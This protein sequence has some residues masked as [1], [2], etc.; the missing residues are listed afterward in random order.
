MTLGTS[1]TRLGLDRRL[2]WWEIERILDLAKAETDEAVGLAVQSAILDHAQ[3]DPAHFR[4]YEH[5]YQLLLTAPYRRSAYYEPRTFATFE[6]EPEP[7]FSCQGEVRDVDP[8]DLPDL[9]ALAE[10]A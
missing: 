9:P 6:H 7:D 10:V 5:A 1:L 8:T 4:Q 2:A 3:S